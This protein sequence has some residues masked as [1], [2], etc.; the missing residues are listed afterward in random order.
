L[1]ALGCV[2]LLAIVAAGTANASTVGVSSVGTVV[3]SGSGF[4]VPITYTLTSASAVDTDIY[5]YDSNGLVVNMLSAGPHSTGTYTVMWNGRYTNGTQAQAD[6]YTIRVSVDNGLSLSCP[7]Y[8]LYVPTSIAFDAAS[9]M[10]LV[11]LKN[12]TKISGG[13]RTILATSAYPDDVAVDT[14]GNVYFSDLE[15]NEVKK[16]APGGTILTLATG[17]SMPASLAVDT[18]GNVYVADTLNRALKKIAP[19]GT[20]TTACSFVS[21]ASWM[22]MDAAGNMYAVDT[23]SGG[24]YGIKRIT[25]GGAVTVLPYGSGSNADMAVDAAGNIYLADSTHESIKRICPNGTVL[26]IASFNDPNGN[27]LGIAIDTAGNLYYSD[28][29]HVMKYATP[30]TIS[31]PVTVNIEQSLLG[32]PCLIQGHV[33]YNGAPV[34]GIRVSTPDAIDYTDSSGNYYLDA[35][36]GTT[37]AITAT[38][39]GHSKTITVTIPAGTSLS[40]NNDITIVYPATYTITL[41]SGWNLIGYP[42]NNPTL[43]AGDIIGTASAHVDMVSAYNNSTDMYTS[44]A[45]GA[46]AWRNVQIASGHGYFIHCTQDSTYTAAG[47]GNPATSVTVYNGWNVLGWSG[48]DIQASVVMSRVPASM[49]ARYDASTAMFKIYYSGASSGHDF[50]L[51]GGDGFFLLSTSST[52][53]TLNIG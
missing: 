46:P 8:N 2:I 7:A 10:Y 37:V 25:P 4:N 39:N 12:I 41:K 30:L 9:N 33:T 35:L 48:D 44:Y 40:V 53:Q 19:D 50:T 20:V 43:R 15:S 11:E 36:S 22:T 14:G 5:I 49:I 52:A 51:R 34:A 42:A 13:T 16:I 28:M 23:I 18:T 29:R 38:C 6:T 3:W 47:T 26:T 24:D 45:T 17:F 32:T 1:P 31:D 21:Y 27:P